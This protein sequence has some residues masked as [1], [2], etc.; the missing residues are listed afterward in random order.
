M[1]KI[2]KTE[3]DHIARL[4]RIELTDKEEEKMTQEIGA[5][6]EYFEKLK[7]V[8]TE[9]VEPTAHVTGSENIFREDDSPHE[10]GEYSK[11]ILDQAPDKKDDFVK[12]KGIL[13]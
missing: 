10:P 8:D 1:S 7:E 2:T 9:G 3:V 4:A 12:V 11:K 5:I 6:L 13:K